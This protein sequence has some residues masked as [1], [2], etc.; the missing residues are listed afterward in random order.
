MYNWGF[1]LTPI[2]GEDQGRR[3]VLLDQMRNRHY[4]TY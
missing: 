4:G 2:R 1:E 3:V